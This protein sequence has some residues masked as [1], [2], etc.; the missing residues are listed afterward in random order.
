MEDC[1]RAQVLVADRGGRVVVAAKARPVA[2]IGPLL[3]AQ[4]ETLPHTHGMEIPWAA[5]HFLLLLF[6]GR[7]VDKAGQ[8]AALALGLAPLSR[9]PSTT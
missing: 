6:L 1:G 5:A 2:P 3:F 7:V 8:R 4:E 9:R